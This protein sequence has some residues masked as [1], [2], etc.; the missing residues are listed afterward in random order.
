MHQVTLD[1]AVPMETYL[2]S[3][4]TNKWTFPL[5][6]LEW[7][8]FVGNC[9]ELRVRR[10][11][12]QPATFPRHYRSQLSRIRLRRTQTNDFPAHFLSQQTRRAPR[13][14]CTLTRRVHGSE[15]SRDAWGSRFRER[16]LWFAAWTYKSEN[17]KL[18]E[19]HFAKIH[20]LKILLKLP[21]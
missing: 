5:Y 8:L 12:C 17:D 3:P 9:R 15:R 2:D 19:N 11:P 20:L 13:R 4:S 21:D 10:R 1:L 14:G 7:M 6:Y 18:I 16:H